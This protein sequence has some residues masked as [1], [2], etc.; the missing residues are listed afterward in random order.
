MLYTKSN[1]PTMIH[2]RPFTGPDF[3]KM[4]HPAL[5]R[6]HKSGRYVGWSCHKVPL[7]KIYLWFDPAKFKAMLKTVLRNVKRMR[8]IDCLAPEYY[9]SY[10]DRYSWKQ[11]RSKIAEDRVITAAIK[12]LHGVAFRNSFCM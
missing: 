4:S 2:H 9:G 3:F 8:D 7:Q 11:L 6:M 12:F 5:Y 1:R 10:K